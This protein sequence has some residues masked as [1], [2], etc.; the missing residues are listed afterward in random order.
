MTQVLDLMVE[1]E[2]L[3]LG[4]HSFSRLFIPYFMNFLWYQINYSLASLTIPKTFLY[5]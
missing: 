3:R 1:M 2:S 4:S 5:L